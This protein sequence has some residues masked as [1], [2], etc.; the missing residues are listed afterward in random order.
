MFGHGFR[1]QFKSFCGLCT[2]CP[3]AN[4]FIFMFMKENITRSGREMSKTK[5][6]SKNILVIDFATL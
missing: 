6:K 5:D 4:D 3:A 2:K 1:L